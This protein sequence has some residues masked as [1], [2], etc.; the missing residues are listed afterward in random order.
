M[1]TEYKKGDRVILSVLPDKTWFSTV[2]NTGQGL[3]CGDR[4]TIL[5]D[6]GDGEFYSSRTALIAFDVSNGGRRVDTHTLDS[7]VGTWIP[8]SCIERLN[9]LDKIAEEMSDY[10]SSDT[11]RSSWGIVEGHGI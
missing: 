1:A 5:L 8:I 9:I 2:I 4:G 7:K 3:D 11:P 6:T 10:D